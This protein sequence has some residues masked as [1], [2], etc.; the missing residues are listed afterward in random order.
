[1]KY[2]G[3]LIACVCFG[4]SF[5]AAGMS[6]VNSLLVPSQTLPAGAKVDVNWLVANTTDVE[7]RVDVPAS[8]Q[9]VLWVGE[10]RWPIVLALVAG[11]SS[12]IP[13]QGF[14]HASY[15]FILP[16]DVSGL[17]TLEVDEPLLLRA[18]IR[19]G[20]PDSIIANE[21]KRDANAANTAAT[22]VSAPLS[23]EYDAPAVSRFQRA[24]LDRFGV[25]QPIYFVFGP[26]KPAAKFQFSFKYRVMSDA[27]RLNAVIPAFR[28]LY[29]GY[30]QRSL[31]DI[32]S[33]SSPFF[34]TSYM[35]ELFFESLASRKSGG[36]G[37]W[38]GYQVGVQHESN[39][40]DGT[41]S[42]S[43]NIAYVRPM[44]ALGEVRGWSLVFAPKLLV[45][46][47][48]LSDN[49]DLRRY[50]GYGEYILMLTKNDS[51]SFTAIGRIGDKWDKGS[52]QVDVNY[53][54]KV[55]YGNFATFL[56]LQYFDGYGESLLRY[57]Q[58]S[59]MIR[60]GFGLV[61]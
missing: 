16:P 42:R 26:D 48:N 29:F 13:A 50:R 21:G 11:R 33:D 3:L 58:T 30:T 9:A 57:N 35:P 59:T 54:L 27:N 45:D 15:E 25:H 56:L 61:R 6:V 52:I 44:F 24:F 5:V 55:K 20:A 19:V 47:D 32:T 37:E 23:E 40:R 1:M 60:A 4:H 53:P 10:R 43:L 39:G 36:L 22:T 14:A 8:L 2:F 49:P 46:I 31:W 38:L 18:S 12:V 34:D 17:A 41:G 51:L 7:A 28:S